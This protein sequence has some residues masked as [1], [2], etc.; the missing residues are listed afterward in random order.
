MQDYKKLLIWK[1]S[2]QLTISIYKLSKDLPKEEIFGLTSQMRRVAV[3]ICSNISERCSRK[4][5][6]D[7]A[8]FLRIS[9]GSLIEI[10]QQ[11]FLSRD[12][13]DLNIKYIE[14]EIIQIS[15]MISTLIKKKNLVNSI[16]YTL[17]TTN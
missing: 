5:S 15:K 10:E 12:L 13:Y 8:R 9:F 6:K 2:Y 14:D 1:I 7:F 11:L 3:S 17:L 16:D 4:S